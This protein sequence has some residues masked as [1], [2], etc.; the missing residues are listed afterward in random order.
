MQ[1]EI[2]TNTNHFEFDYVISLGFSCHIAK[3][4]DLMA[5][6]DYAYPFDWII[7]DMHSV[8]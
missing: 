5:Y 1:K 2:K 7:S 6:R 8:A 3:G 4:P